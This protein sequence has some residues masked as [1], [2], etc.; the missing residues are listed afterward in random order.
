LY[1]T[2][3][4]VNVAGRTLKCTWNRRR[5]HWSIDRLRCLNLD[6]NPDYFCFGSAFFSF[7]TWQFVY[8]SALHISL[9]QGWRLF[10]CPDLLPRCFTTRA[11]RC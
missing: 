1:S 4:N 9:K 7:N 10:F 3:S 2:F 5:T 6:S 8:I 11:S